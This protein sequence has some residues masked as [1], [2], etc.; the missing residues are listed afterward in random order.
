MLVIIFTIQEKTI[1]RKLADSTSDPI[2]LQHVRQALSRFQEML[3]SSPPE[4]QK[5]LLQT[6]V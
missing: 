2:P 6:M 5:T 4:M 3:K 1:Q